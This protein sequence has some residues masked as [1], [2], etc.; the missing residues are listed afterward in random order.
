MTRRC[1]RLCVLGVNE[2]RNDPSL[3][4]FM[5]RNL[6]GSYECVC[7]RGQMLLA[8]RKTCAGTYVI[9]ALSFIA[10][11]YSHHALYKACAQKRKRKFE[12]STLKSNERELRYCCAHFCKLYI[13]I[14]SASFL[15]NKLQHTNYTFSFNRQLILT[16][17]SWLPSD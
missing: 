6:I 4:T 13:I 3:C 2:C 9:I 5:C 14:H 16:C 17:N 8:D 15:C 10:K 1:A 12:W 7:P 11:S